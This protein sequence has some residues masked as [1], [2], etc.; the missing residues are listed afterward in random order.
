MPI[1]S[2]D[3]GA[4]TLRESEFD[5]RFMVDPDVPSVARSA[6]RV[7][8]IAVLRALAGV[9][10]W[11]HP[12]G[13]LTRFLVSQFCLDG[14]EFCFIK[15]PLQNR[16]TFRRKRCTDSRCR[17]SN[18]IQVRIDYR[19]RAKIVP[20]PKTVRASQ[21]IA[22][23]FRNFRRTSVNPRAKDLASTRYTDATHRMSAANP[24]EP[25]NPT[26]SVFARILLSLRPPNIA[27]I[28]LEVKCCQRDCRAGSMPI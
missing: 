19:S 24:N 23:V 8:W 10:G 6:S 15:K 12:S 4:N 1:R 16:H 11:K 22:Q 26:R 13:M 18:R 21:E 5:R 9:G 20:I 7:F 2:S 27:L 25:M 28:G 3:A 17:C 14:G